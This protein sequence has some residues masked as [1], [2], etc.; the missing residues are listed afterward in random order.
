MKK[1]LCL[2]LFLSL[3]SIAFENGCITA[4]TF[5]I[6]S[7]ADDCWR[8]WWEAT[9]PS[10]GEEFG[11]SESPNIAGWSRISIPGFS[12]YV[13]VHEA[14]FRFTNIPLPQGTDIISATI[15]VKQDATAST[16]NLDIQACDEDNSA[17]ISSFAN[18][19]S[20]ART[21]ANINW[22]L[23]ASANTEY[24]SPDI[25]TIIEEV[26]ARGSWSSGNAIQIIISDHIY[27]YPNY[28]PEPGDTVNHQLRAVDY[29]ASYEVTLT[30]E[31]YVDIGLRVRTSGGTIKIG[32]LALDGHALRVRKGGTTYGIPLLATSDDSASGL[33]IYDG[34]AVKALPKVD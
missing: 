12:N 10:S 3:A 24:T 30:I 31:F 5:T 27:K 8:T 2:I 26:V 20:R 28:P 18:F 15:K 4:S 6:P 34:S 7:G 11:N 22:V 23:S 25:K 29:G 17:Q 14:A 13:A 21:T 16:F 33:R 9:G 19:G 32:T 1:I